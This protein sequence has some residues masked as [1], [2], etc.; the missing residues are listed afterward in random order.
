[1]PSWSV[2]PSTPDDYPGIVDVRIRG[3][4]ATY[5]HVMPAGFLDRIEALRDREIEGRRARRGEAAFVE[6]VGTIDDRIVGWAISGDPTDPAAPAGREL[7]ALYTD[8]ATH[9][10]GL[11]TALLDAV[12]GDAPASLWVL[13][14][15]PRARAFYEKSGFAPDG[16]RKMLDGELAHIPEI[17]MVRPETI[18]AGR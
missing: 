18:Q 5:S 16:I 12:L 8:A 1:M 13:E 10:S 14:D 15:N 11:A 17:R 4:R 3:W 9:G 6:Y 2:R 7:Y